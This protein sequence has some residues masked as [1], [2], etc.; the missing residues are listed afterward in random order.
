MP[1]LEFLE[2]PPLELQN[3]DAIYNAAEQRREVTDTLRR[4]TLYRA[5]KAYIQQCVPGSVRR[6]VKMLLTRP[7][8]VPSQAKMSDSVRHWV[9]ESL[10]EDEEKLASLLGLRSPLWGEIVSRRR[11]AG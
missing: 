10:R 9:M 6:L 8:P 7:A 11:L 2:L 3:P 5:Y 1:I 4:I